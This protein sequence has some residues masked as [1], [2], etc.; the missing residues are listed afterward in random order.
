MMAPCKNDVVETSNLLSGPKPN[1]LITKSDTYVS[2]TGTVVFKNEFGFLNAELYPLVKYYMISMV[3]FGVITTVWCYL[4]K[5]YSE[6][7]I[8][9]HHFVT[10]LIAL[11]LL[12]SILM[13]FEY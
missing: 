12:E 3:I 11:G 7:L 13:F 9:V 10:I 4:L 1:H 8:V 2:L 5:R 6:Y